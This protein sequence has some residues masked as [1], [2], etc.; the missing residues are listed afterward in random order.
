MSV[1]ASH[2]KSAC[3]KD[4]SSV[5]SC[6]NNQT[7]YNLTWIKPIKMQK[8]LARQLCQSLVKVTSKANCCTQFSTKFRDDLTFSSLSV[9][10]PWWG[11]SLNLSLGT[12]KKRGKTFLFSLK[13]FSDIPSWM[14]TFSRWCL[15]IPWTWLT[16]ICTAHASHSRHASEI[17]ASTAG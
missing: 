10:Y 3:R 8:Y 1:Y 15:M 7:Y 9:R 12:A 17:T 5:S 13:W 4:T 14:R 6:K 11:N 16:V 2:M